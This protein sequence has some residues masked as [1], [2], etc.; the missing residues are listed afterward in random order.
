MPGMYMF[1]NSLINSNSLGAAADFIN[2]MS[3]F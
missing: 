1:T 2:F 3:L